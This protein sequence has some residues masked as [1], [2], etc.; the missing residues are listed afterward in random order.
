MRKITP[1]L[2]IPGFFGVHMNESGVI[3][4]SRLGAKAGTG[5]QSLGMFTHARVPC[6]FVDGQIYDIDVPEESGVAE[7]INK[8]GLMYVAC[9][10]MLKLGEGVRYAKFQVAKDGTVTQT[11]FYETT[12]PNDDGLWVGVTNEEPPRSPSGMRKKS[13][14]QSIFWRDG[15]T[16]PIEDS[17]FYPSAI[18]NRGAVACSYFGDDKQCAIMIDGALRP[19]RNDDPA[20]GYVEAMN[21]RNE[22]LLHGDHGH[23]DM[24]AIWSDGEIEMI[25]FK[26]DWVFENGSINS[27][28]EIVGSMFTTPFNMT[29]SGLI[30]TQ[31][32]RAFAW[33]SGR[34]I[35]L[36]ERT[37]L[38][39]RTAHWVD[40]QSR[41]LC[42]TPDVTY[43]LPPEIFSE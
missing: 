14:S 6:M 29:F 39:I 12:G 1:I 19:I 16:I 22:V 28:R 9:G 32:G 20:F 8:Y 40:E 31:S 34:F 25:R 10:P 7:R 35:D 43:V 2:T 30:S 37:G 23:M 24:A 3:V 42:Q 17:R 38:D 27:K 21:D 41:V 33:K 26:K 15:E 4:G 5:L 13:R 11:P 36:S 18:N